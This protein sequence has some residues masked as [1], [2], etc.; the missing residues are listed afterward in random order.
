MSGPFAVF[1]V[2]GTLVDSRA[3]IQTCMARAFVATGLTAPPYERV[4]RVIGLSLGPGLDVLAPELDADGRRALFEAYRAAFF[5]LRQDPAHAEPLYDGVPALL[6][7]LAA[8]GW[9]LGIATG[10]SRRGLDAHLD[11]FGW[12]DL[13][14]T[15]WCAD[16]GPGKP[17]P[18]MVVQNMAAVGALPA[19]TIV[20]GDTD[21]DMAMARAA[22]A[23]AQ[24]VAWGFGRREEMTGAG[25]GHVAETMDALAASL[26]DFAAG[27]RETAAPGI[28][29]AAR[30]L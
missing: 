30:S 7:G 13:F 15:H 20:I 3:L 22:G 28:E 21:H 8:S 26:R 25:A 2:D 27:L 23:A 6:E 10:K 18:H 24:G 1:D 29:T 12:R 11:R 16:D 14:A 19:A 17:H 9:T 4:R 5:E